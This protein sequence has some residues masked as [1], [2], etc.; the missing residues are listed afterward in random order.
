[1]VPDA[2]LKE[3]AISG[4]FHDELMGRVGGVTAAGRTQVAAKESTQPTKRLAPAWLILIVLLMLGFAM[5][6]DRGVLR[7][8]QANRHKADLQQ[9]L[10]LL[11]EERHRLKVEIKQLR[12]D[13]DY[14]EQLARKKLGMVREGELIYQFEEAQK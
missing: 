1:M 9:E 8:L 13:K 7:T 12:Q 11:Q 5:F 2:F 3:E 6:G 14:L 10:Q 4:F